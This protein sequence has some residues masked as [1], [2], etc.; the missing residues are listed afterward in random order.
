MCSIRCGFSCCIQVA[1]WYSASVSVALVILSLDNSYLRGPQLFW[2]TSMALGITFGIRESIGDS[3][4]GNCN[5]YTSFWIPYSAII[6]QGKILAKTLPWNSGGEIFGK[7][8][9][10]CAYIIVPKH[11][12][13]QYLKRSARRGTSPNFYMCVIE[14]VVVS[15]FEFT[16][17]EATTSSY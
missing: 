14:C 13:I 4:I 17:N 9:S 3:W 8:S 10:I 15:T 16:V 1:L 6:G 7:S 12:K 2:I 11:Q 5:F